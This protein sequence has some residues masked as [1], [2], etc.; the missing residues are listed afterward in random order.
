MQFGVS[1]CCDGLEVDLG[2]CSD[3]LSGPQV[4]WE[5]RVGM[6]VIVFTMQPSD[7]SIVEM[8]MVRTFADIAVGTSC[9]S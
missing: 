7:C 1:N 3:D 6:A 9:F 5:A 2:R 8:T 4:W